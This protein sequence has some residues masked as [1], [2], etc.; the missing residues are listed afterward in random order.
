MNLARESTA[1]SDVEYTGRSQTAVT[2]VNNTASSDYR[3]G[4]GLARIPTGTEQGRGRKP[5]T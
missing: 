1:D 5:H 2:R 3:Y 4:G